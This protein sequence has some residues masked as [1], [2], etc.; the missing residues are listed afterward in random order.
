MSPALWDAY[1]M[2]AVQGMFALLLL[3][4]SM[5]LFAIA[6]RIFFGEES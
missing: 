1:S 2:A 5:L 6:Y 3:A 4:V